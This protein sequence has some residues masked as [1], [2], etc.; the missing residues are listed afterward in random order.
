MNYPDDKTF[1]PLYTEEELSLTDKPVEGMGQYSSLKAITTLATGQVLPDEEISFDDTV[2]AT[3]DITSAEDDLLDSIVAE[4]SLIS[5]AHPMFQQTMTEMAQ[6]NQLRYKESA[7]KYDIQR[8]KLEDVSRTAVENIIASRPKIVTNNSV[9]KVAAVAE[10]I[11]QEFKGKTTL[12]RALEDAYKLTTIAKGV[13]AI[14]SPVSVTEGYALES[15]AV[16]Y[17]VPEDQFSF[18]TG[19]TEVRDALALKFQRLPDNEKEKWLSALYDDAKASMR[20]SDFRAAILIGEIAGNEDSEWDGFFDY[21][22]KIGAVGVAFGLGRAL[23]RGS[24]G[25]SMAKKLEDSARTMAKAGAKDDLVTVE[26]IKIQRET[27]R[28]ARNLAYREI[29]GEATGISTVLDM[30]KLVSLNAF[31]KEAS[32]ITTASADLQRLIQEPTVKLIDDLQEVVAAKG[33]GSDEAAE[34][35]RLLKDTFSNANNPH[36]QSV[37]NFEISADGTTLSTRVYYKPK[38][39]TAFA[40]EKAAQQYIKSLDPA[41]TRGMKVVPDTSNNTF[42]V[43]EA[44]EIGLRQKR[45]ELETQILEQLS[46]LEKTE[47]LRERRLRTVEEGRAISVPRLKGL[48]KKRID[49]VDVV[50]NINGKQVRVVFGSDVDKSAYIASKMVDEVDQTTFNT[51]NDFLIDMMRWRGQN[52]DDHA[53]MLLSE[54]KA[55]SKS[56]KSGDTLTLES[57]APS[58]ASGMG[59]RPKLTTRAQG[60]LDNVDKSET[61]G[62]VTIGKQI[63][64]GGYR[65]DV[66]NFMNT[67]GKSLGMDDRRIVVMTLDDLRNG[68]RDG[69]LVLSELYDASLTYKD[70]GAL[71][72]AY[73]HKVSVIVMM[74]TSMKKRGLFM[75]N[76]AHELGHAFEAHFS[77]KHFQTIHNAFTA[78]LKKKN[79]SYTGTGVNLKIADIIPFEAMIEHRGVMSARAMQKWV[80]DYFN[81]DMKLYLDNEKALHNWMADYSEFFAENFAKWAF[82]D[83][84]PTTIL[85]EFFAELVAKFKALVV[86]VNEYFKAEGLVV[87]AGDVDRRLARMLNKHIKDHA[88]MVSDVK[89]NQAKRVKIAKENPEKS[90][91]RLKEELDDIDETL[92]AI[93]SAKR[94]L[95]SGYLVQQ[96][97][98]K[99]ITYKALKGYSDADIDSASRWAMGEWSRTTS[100]EQYDARV[101]GIHQQSRYTKLLTNYIR[102]DIEALNKTE[103]VALDNILVLGDKEGKVFS[104]TELAGHNLSE[105]TRVAYYKVRALRDVMWNMRNESAAKSLIRRGYKEINFGIEFDNGMEAKFFG[106]EVKRPEDGT[107]VYDVAERKNIRVTD[108]SIEDATKKGYIFV[109]SYDTHKLDGANRKTFM[110]K[111]DDITQSKI[112]KVIPYRAGEYRRIYSDEYFVKI[113]SEDLVDGK[114]V[115][116]TRTHRTATSN[117]DA[118]KY[119]KAFNEAHALYKAGKLDVAS[120]DDL[121]QAYG[122]N[123]EELIKA[124]DNGEFGDNIKNVEVRYN[125]SDDDYINEAININ[126]DRFSARGDRVLSVHGEDAINTVSPLDSIAAEISNTAY[127]ASVNEWREVSVHKWFKTFKSVLPSNVQRM[128]PDQAFFHMLNNKGQYLGN[129]KRVVTAQRVQDYL[130]SQ[131]NIATKEEKATAGVLRVISENYLTKMGTKVGVSE[132]NMAKA[133]VLLRATKDYD[134][135][136]RTIA[137]HSYFAFN[138]VQFFMQSMN[139]FNAVAISPI[140]GLR[141]AKTSSLYAIA[142]MSDQPEIWEKI[143]KLNSVGSLGTSVEEFVESVRMLKRSGLLDSLNT[144][145]LYGAHTGKYGI[146]NGWRRKLGAVSGATFNA[147]E[148]LSRIVS[149]EIA[150][151]EF[152]SANKGRAWWSDDALVEVLARQDDLTQNMTIANKTFMQRGILS[153][154]FQFMQYPV[155]MAIHMLQGITGAKRGL[156]RKEVLSLLVIHGLVMGTSGNLLWPFDGY[157]E[158]ALKEMYGDELTDESRLYWQ[159]GMVAGVIGSVTDGEVKLGLGSRF[160]TFKYYQ[161]F[162]R[163][164]FF[165][166][167]DTTALDVLFGASGPAVLRALGGF[168]EAYATI[169]AQPMSVET[170]QMALTEIGTGAF[171]SLNN[172]QKMRIAQSN[173]NTV[174]ST[175]GTPMYSVTDMETYFIGLGIPMAKQEDLSIRYES[176]KAFKDDIKSAAD[177]VGRRWL[178]ATTALY[179]NDRESY[180]RHFAVVQAI[181]NDYKDNY[182]AH[183]QLL[184]VLLKSN[185]TTK[186][187]EMMVNQLIKDIPIQELTS[188][189]TD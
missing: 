171:S 69:N 35:L 108:E 19:Q 109:E 80:D 151:R 145:S 178:M 63:I 14:I 174:F 138:P 84:V 98:E 61:V 120:A 118:E 141:S 181:M 137:F 136:M 187:E 155:N 89:P 58:P 68:K 92:S 27:A 24:K 173:Y 8:K 11:T 86:S 40:T 55:R 72:Y 2:N 100:K 96:D 106:R 142:L 30:A 29:A 122:W 37:D 139:A 114:V 169:V 77:V 175:K 111:P 133:G 140:H 73:G 165:N 9:E 74:P 172:I 182:H 59:S 123:A 47:T 101:T 121:M 116:N 1:D 103:R 7:D 28:K 117:V 75:E 3:W 12:E 179:N 104:E 22:D 113:I 64:N 43:E 25:I 6:R 13:G 148:G 176:E 129:D 167:E 26:A 18:S 94:G 189:G 32:T 78:W 52:T 42:F 185:Y 110:V 186:L 56:L 143:A 62:N 168:G 46:K 158:D 144:A 156:T 50:A 150:R 131:L 147:G 66:F 91:E 184:N 128:S 5:K 166:P 119:V 57:M 159:Q 162:V 134:V 154:P 51:A 153:I 180:E 102:P 188:E 152:K 127:V 107:Y 160:N 88:K 82:S 183:Q 20:I 4:D 112:E 79:I 81:G 76:F 36:I 125:R 41:T 124:F 33:I 157:V 85:G 17:G 146:F 71:H 105:K 83:K 170:L 39:A 49:D 23:V 149:F 21:A 126:S 65:N 177:T 135:F 161:D 99:T 95:H 48:Y 31:R 70:A 90:I 87:T 54:I 130:V 60:F 164:T 45:V 34:Q 115:V 44:V 16:K 10:E 38:D 132:E 67:L 97:I 53:S 93:D 163:N 15:L